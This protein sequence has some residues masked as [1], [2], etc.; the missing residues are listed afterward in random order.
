M[1]LD[2]DFGQTMDE[3]TLKDGLLKLNSNFVFDPGGRLNMYHPQIS[4]RQGV[5][6]GLNHI[7]S[8]ERGAAIPEYNVWG[9]VKDRKTGSLRKSHIVRVGWRHTLQVIVDRRVP[10]VTWDQIHRVF[11]IVRKDFV[12]EP[13]MLEVARM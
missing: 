8:M 11:D 4:T 3:K 12:G 13:M 9:L 1:N 6:I 7:C 2:H 5:Y 10:G